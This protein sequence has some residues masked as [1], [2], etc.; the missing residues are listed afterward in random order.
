MIR[1]MLTW[2]FGPKSRFTLNEAVSLKDHT[3]LM[4]VTRITSDFS[5]EPVI[6]CQWSD[7]QTVSKGRFSESELEPFDWTAAYRQSCRNACAEEGGKA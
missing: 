7:G 2:A 4:I 5:K 1:Q 3:D 6:E